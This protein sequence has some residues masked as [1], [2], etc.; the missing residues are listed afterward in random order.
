MYHKS[1]KSSIFVNMAVKKLSTCT[2][3]LVN[4]AAIGIL[5]ITPAVEA[6]IQNYIWS[7][8]KYVPKQF[9][10]LVEETCLV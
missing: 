6:K 1:V 7:S 8:L 4:K 9:V 2:V 3:C 5:K 10:P